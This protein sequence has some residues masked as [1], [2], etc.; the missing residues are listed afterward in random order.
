MCALL[1][2]IKVTVN[3][4]IMLLMLI[5]IILYHP[6]DF[7]NI[8]EES[9]SDNIPRGKI[10]SELI[11]FSMEER[12]DLPWEA[13]ETEEAKMLSIEYHPSLYELS[14]SDDDSIQSLIF[15]LRKVSLFS[16]SVEK[17]NLQPEGQPDKNIY[18]NESDSYRYQ[19]FKF[20]DVAERE[21]YNSA[22]SVTTSVPLF[23]SPLSSSPLSSPSFQHL[24]FLS[25]SS[26]VAEII[27]PSFNADLLMDEN[28]LGKASSLRYLHTLPTW[29]QQ[30]PQ[31][32][33]PL[34]NS[35]SLFELSSSGSDA[36]I[37]AVIVRAKALAR[38]LR[39]GDHA[40][41]VGD[42][43]IVSSLSNSSVSSETISERME[44]CSSDSSDDSDD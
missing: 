40:I 18:N 41:L 43:V 17:F 25:E 6:I 30:Q 16:P 21:V 37:D 34:E 31:L 20:F 22:R 5:I 42:E 4:A 19:A 29:S 7:T 2:I 14:D 3:V 38:Q 15:R 44:S 1:M 35:P 9:I 39:S 32:V 11:R 28:L 26:S 27:S 33:D 13:V 24:T 12:A 10:V 36:S 23:P 8:L